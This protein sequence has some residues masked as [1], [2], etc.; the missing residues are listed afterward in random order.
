MNQRNKVKLMTISALLCA[1]GIMIPMYFPKIVVEPA[2]F[3]LASHVPIIIAI[4]ISPAVALSVAVITGFGFLIAGFPM[5]VVLRA[6]SHLAF[7]AL[8]SFIIKKNNSI[9]LSLKSSVIFSFLIAVVHA[10]AEVAVVTYFYWGDQLKDIFYEK[11]YVLSVLVLV[12]LGTIIHSM[13]DFT[14]ATLVWRP[15]Q[16]A[17]S[18]P[19]Y[20]KAGRMTPHNN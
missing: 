8:G 2:S 15:L 13:L 11:G 17:V 19:A 20:A 18:I 4:F 5:V 1:I 10:V 6:F 3:T 7:A 14:I 9:L 16:H 12:G